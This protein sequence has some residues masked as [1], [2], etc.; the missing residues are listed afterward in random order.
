MERLF[1]RRPGD[2]GG[3]LNMTLTGF[4]D[5]GFYSVRVAALIRT[6]GAI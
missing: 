3:E 5:V 6:R 1:L 4:I 2:G